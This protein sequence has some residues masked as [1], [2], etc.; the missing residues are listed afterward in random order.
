MERV[1]EEHGG[2]RAP[3]GGSRID[4]L[5]ELIRSLNQG[6]SL[7]EVFDLI[8]DRLREFVPYNR[9]AVA[10]TDPAC[11]KLTILV[12]RSDGKMVLGKGYSGPVAGS[13]LEP[14]LREGRLR[15]INDLRAYLEGKPSSESTRLIVKEGMRSSL[16]LPLL[17]EGKPVGVMFF[18][19]RQAGAYGPEHEDF[20]RGI[21]GHMAIAIERTRLMDELR[22]K[23]EYLESILNNTAEA[24]VV[25]D[26][27]NRIRTWNEGARRIFGY[28]SEE[29]V[30]KDFGLILPPEVCGGAEEARI[31]DVVE[32]QGFASFEACE[33]LTKDGRRIRVSGTSTLLRDKRGRVIGRSSIVRDVTELNRLQEELIRARSLAAV[34]ELA[35]TVAHEI[36]NPL[37]GISGAVQV[38]RDAMAPDDSRREVVAEILEQIRRLDRI[39]RDL[40][41]FARPATP[42]RQEV[43]LAESVSRAWALLAPQAEAAGIRHV[44]EGAEGLTVSADPHLLQQVWI[45]L[46]QNAIEAMPEGGEL[47]VAAAPSEG[48]VRV[49]V[50]DTGTG[51]EP[52]H[53]GDVF[54]PFFSTKARGTGL[55]LA[56]TRK[57]VEAHGGTI[58]L[59]SAPG[60]GTTVYVEI[61]R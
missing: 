22:E 42:A 30:G 27:Q 10:V 31:R 48:G 24:I 29:V 41:V 8:Y 61:P 60:R 33:R 2:F 51:I 18:S 58:R 11:R 7:E 28:E 5:N 46:F 56:I 17:V 57:I 26:A 50:R 40:L 53:A 25:V 59:E 3:P 6:V 55:G 54:K 15:I 14:L 39:V 38:L 12:V 44:A 36:K 1:S 21:V 13:S 9:I 49:E 45:N 20:L 52:A 23:T 19:S 47:R 43:I 4:L 16:T 32:E 34:G 37:A 35:A